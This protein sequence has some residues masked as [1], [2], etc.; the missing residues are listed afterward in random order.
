MRAGVPRKTAS[1]AG[2]PMET[3]HID[4]AGPCE[5]SVGGSHYLVM[6]VDGASRW[7]QPHGMRNKSETTAYVQFLADANTMGRPLCLRKDN[8]GK[9]T[10]RSFVELFDAAGITSPRRQCRF[11]A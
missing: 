11:S 10:G 4:L 2:R 1:R 7:M 3:V 9:F 6:F 5:A 8:G